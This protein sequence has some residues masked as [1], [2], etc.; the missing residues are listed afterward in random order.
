MVHLIKGDI[1]NLKGSPVYIYTE[2][3]FNSKKPKDY[4]WA[5]NM[6]LDLKNGDLL[7]ICFS[8]KK[9]GFESGFSRDVPDLFKKPLQ[10]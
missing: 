9:K 8:N 6:G 2:L 3:N 4:S 7:A 1:K 5:K 10:K